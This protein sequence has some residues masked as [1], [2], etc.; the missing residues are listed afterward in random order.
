MLLVASQQL[1]WSSDTLTGRRR[2]RRRA[3]RPDRGVGTDAGHVAQAERGDLRSQLG[4]VAV[5]GIHQHHALRQPRGS[6]RL[7]LLQG[8]LG[9]VWKAIVSGTLALCRRA[10]SLAHSSGR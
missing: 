7:D 2:Q 10:G 6:G 9:L 4:V 8:D 3:R 1:G 5:A